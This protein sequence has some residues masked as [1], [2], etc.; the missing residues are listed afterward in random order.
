MVDHFITFPCSNN[1]VN[2]I[3]KSHN[4]GTE[5]K[6]EFVFVLLIGPNSEGK[7]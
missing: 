7:W 2:L 5:V 3:K 1:V 4:G 6:V